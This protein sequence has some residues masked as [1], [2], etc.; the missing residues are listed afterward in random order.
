MVV[1]MPAWL[2]FHARVQEVQVE[3]IIAAKALRAFARASS[4]RYEAKPLF[5]L[6]KARVVVTV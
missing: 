6:G 1:A 3:R 5:E 4:H 2:A